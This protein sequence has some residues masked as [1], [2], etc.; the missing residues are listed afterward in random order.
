[1]IVG[2]AAVG[3]AGQ[4]ESSGHSPSSS[5]PAKKAHHDYLNQFKDDDDDDVAVVT[6]EVSVYLQTRVQ[7]G[8]NAAAANVVD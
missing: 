5:P 4:S 2:F 1:M 7:A 3:V 6:D 8:D